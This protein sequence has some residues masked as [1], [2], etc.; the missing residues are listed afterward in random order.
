MLVESNKSPQE[1]AVCQ[2]VLNRY[3]P[4]I[5]PTTV[6][7]LGNRG[8]FS[9]AGIWRVVTDQGNFA[10]RRWPRAQLPTARILG[11][12]RLLTQIDCDGLTIVSV[13]LKTAD[14]TTLPHESG[15][16]W[17]LEPWLRGRAD[18]HAS[19]TAERVQSVMMALARWHQL[20]ERHVPASGAAEWFS[21]RRDAVSPAVGERLQILAHIDD[22]SLSRI[23]TSIQAI[24]NPQ[25]QELTGRIA[26]C[27]RRGRNQIAQE[28]RSVC[29]IK[30]RLHPCLRDIWHDHLLFTGDELTGLIDPSASRTE[31]VACDLSRLIGSLFGDDR[32]GWDQSLNEYQRHRALTFGELRLIKALDRSGVL[33]SG[34]TWLEWICLKQRTFSDIETVVARLQTIQSR[35]ETLDH[36]R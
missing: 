36:A 18:F 17:Q 21:S 13:P 16:D 24:V 22:S 9:G 5:I 7:S 19:P 28:L 1:E 31:N 10:L 20:A 23:A 11:L 12:H 29:D 3:F 35:M 33:L 4:R 6:E 14:G 27:L 2:R 32:R 25:I 8:G 26:A 15:D 30:V 34:W